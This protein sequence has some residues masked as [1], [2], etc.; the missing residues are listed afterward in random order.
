MVILKRKVPHNRG[1]QIEIFL[2]Q[3]MINTQISYR[4][5]RNAKVRNITGFCDKARIKI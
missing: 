2:I 5:Y 1:V 4:Y 3:L